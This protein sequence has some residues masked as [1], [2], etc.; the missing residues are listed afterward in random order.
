MAK[1]DAT[2][3]D[4]M[5]NNRA[6]V[7]DFNRHFVQWTDASDDARAAHPHQVDIAYGAGSMERLDVFPAKTRNAPVVVFIHGGYWR[8]LD[9]S[10]H[11]FLAPAFTNPGACVV[12][13]NYALC[14]TVTIPEIVLQMVQALR[15][16]WLNIARFGGDKNRITVIGHS[17]GGHLATMLLACHWPLVDKKLPA[18]LVKGA[19]SI[20]GLYDLDPV[21][22]TPFLKD[23]LRLTE[24]QVQQV[25]PAWMPAPRQGQLYTLA[26]AQESAE[27]IRHNTMMQQAWGKKR[28]PVC[29]LVAER[30]HF[31]VLEDLSAPWTRLHAL[32][33]KLVFGKFPGK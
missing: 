30:N 3:L 6:L 21:M 16:T 2:W 24:Q 7:P 8:G 14:P 23:D 33:M 19:M 1:W 5:Y 29:E 9:K 28:V 22:H 25:S 4:G 15:W 31:S 10:Q 32:A 11:S 13:P 18:D 12:I 26:G 17:A 27:F 20:S